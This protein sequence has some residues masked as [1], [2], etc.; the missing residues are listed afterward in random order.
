MGFGRVEPEV[1]P[2]DLRVWIRSVHHRIRG[3]VKR[4]AEGG[5]EEARRH[6]G[7]YRRAL[8]WSCGIARD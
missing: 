4:Q 5:G 6:A 1:F 2:D 3:D 8:E 7:D